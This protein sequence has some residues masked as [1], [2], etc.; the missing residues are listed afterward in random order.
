[1][2][3]DLRFTICTV[4]FISSG[5]FFSW[6]LNFLSRFRKVFCG[7]GW[8]GCGTHS[9][10]LILL[11]S[12]STPHFPQRYY[13]SPLPLHIEAPCFLT[14]SEGGRR[15]LVSCSVLLSLWSHGDI[16]GVGLFAWKSFL[17]SILIE[18]LTLLLTPNY[19]ENTIIL[20]CSFFPTSLIN[21]TLSWN[22]D[23]C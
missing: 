12:Y 6:D 16:T 14:M 21:I 17:Y 15:E 19:V 11:P 18:S 5:S 3:H 1:M 13:Q 7:G 2:C 20:P 23:L 8:N 22:H 9:R 10:P 4:D